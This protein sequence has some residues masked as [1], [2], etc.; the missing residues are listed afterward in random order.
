MT[1]RETIEVEFD[2]ELLDEARELGLD[3]DA[4]VEAALE[5]A[6]E[7]RKADLDSERKKDAP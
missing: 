4:V 2:A 6:I 1:D 7:A 5:K 3:L